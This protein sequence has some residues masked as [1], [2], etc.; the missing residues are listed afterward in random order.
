MC[1]DQYD[2]LLALYRQPQK[3]MDVHLN[4]RYRNGLNAD[5][6]LLVMC[7][8]QAFILYVRK[9]GI[10]LGPTEIA[11]QL[12]EIVKKARNRN[13]VLVT[14]LA[15]ATTAPREDA[16][17]FWESMVLNEKNARSLKMIQTAVFGICLDGFV[18]QKAFQDNQLE[19]AG[20]LILHGCGPSGNGLN[21]WYDTT[22]QVS[23]LNFV[24][25]LII[26]L[27]RGISRRL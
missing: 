1:M 25:L 19:T 14:P 12:A 7:E 5:Q 27:A 26:I 18:P 4:E 20:D 15:A 13:K 23:F 9:D 24:L 3:G 6:H 22:I 17:E 2:R 16:A 21:R 10:S 11:L 8:A